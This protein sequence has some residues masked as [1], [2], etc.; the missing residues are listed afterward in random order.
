LSLAE[1]LLS[2]IEYYECLDVAIIMPKIFCIRVA[3]TV[4]NVTG[5]TVV[6]V[7]LLVDGVLAVETVA[8]IVI[9]V[10]VRM[11]LVVVVRVLVVTAV[12]AEA[13][14]VIVEVELVVESTAV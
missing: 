12:D 7:L 5:M 8:V 1:L 14:K 10:L 9:V 2:S 13:V 6:S 4:D 3:K 11:V